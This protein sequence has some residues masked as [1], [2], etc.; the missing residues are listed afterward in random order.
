[1]TLTL[2]L[3]IG[4]LIAGPPLD[5]HE[6]LVAQTAREMVRSRDFIDP[7]FAGQPRWQKPPLAYWLVSGSYMLTGS[8]SPWSARLPSALA[9]V[10]LTGLVVLFARRFASKGQRNEPLLAGVIHSVVP[11]TL[12]SGTS[13]TVDMVL[14][15]LVAATIYV[16]TSTTTP[17]RNRILMT[18]SLL[19]LVLL[20]KGPI[21]AIITLGAIAPHA[22]M[23][24][25]SGGPIAWAWHVLGLA[26]LM[27]L[28]GTWPAMVMLEN[29]EVVRLWLDQSLGRYI[30]H[31]GPQ[32]RPWFYY[33]YQVPA[34]VGPWVI[35][36]SL[37]L[38]QS[39]RARSRLLVGWF[40]FALV[41]LS[42]SEG[43]RDHYIL[44]ALLPWSVWAGIGGA[45]AYAM[46]SS[47]L[48]RSSLITALS[49]SSLG[50]ACLEVSE[51]SRETESLAPLTQWA[52]E[53]RDE[54]VQARGVLQVGWNNH[55]TAFTIDRPMRWVA[56]LTSI[57]NP[58]DDF[59]FDWVI[60]MGSPRGVI[61]HNWQRTKQI[62]SP[63][64]ARAIA[65]YRVHDSPNAIM[66]VPLQ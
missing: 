1:M 58:T 10:A 33:L 17:K 20:A 34:L 16:A 2:L 7:V 54:L 24:R 23:V 8:V 27:I 55:A 19:S 5:G 42:C 28:A 15:F 11:W 47:R 35:M 36:G 64:A 61:P 50:L 56:D 49:L 3:Q 48:A 9:A 21:G 60:V 59:L 65:I 38:V 4:F 53:H 25:R 41:F 32:T 62:D 43:K 45:H 66:P 52:H 14:A 29:P 6:A 44:P 31:W 13:A 37:A 12:V 57:A 22:W 63:D 18:W 46:I 40:L 51:F 26:I 39:N 30:E